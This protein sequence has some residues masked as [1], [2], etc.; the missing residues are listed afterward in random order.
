MISHRFGYFST[1]P[2]PLPRGAV[3]GAVG[4][5]TGL[6]EAMK[7]AVGASYCNHLRDQLREWQRGFKAR[8]GRQP[9]LEDFDALQHDSSARGKLVHG[10]YLALNRSTGGSFAKVLFTLTL[11]NLSY[12]ISSIVTEGWK[13]A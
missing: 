4:R 8:T 6:I 12:G 7:E 2:H 5:L 3:Q 10:A 11:T 1:V 13:S 9:T